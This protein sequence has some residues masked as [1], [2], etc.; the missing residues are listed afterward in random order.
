MQQKLELTSADA[1]AA[2][3]LA[4]LDRPDFGEPPVGDVRE[5]A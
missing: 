1:A 5:L 3:V 4:C 2:R